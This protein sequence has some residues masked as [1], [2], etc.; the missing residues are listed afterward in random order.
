MVICTPTPARV[1]NS[2]EPLAMSSEVDYRPKRWAHGVTGPNA[3]A[4][5]FT[6][7]L[8][9]K[10]VEL[11]GEGLPHK[12]ICPLVGITK[13][14]FEN[15]RDRAHSGEEPYAT[16]LQEVDAARAADAQRM[17]AVAKEQIIE[18]G[19]PKYAL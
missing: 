10:F 17:I 13:E 9:A 12:V 4:S 3:I 16:F 7:E 8:H 1:N 11:A 18:K 6:P 2:G 14:T 5:K 15:W 19:D